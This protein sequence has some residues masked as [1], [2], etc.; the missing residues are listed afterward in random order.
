M[1]WKQQIEEAYESG[2]TRE[3]LEPKRRVGARDSGRE[4][5]QQLW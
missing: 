2:K 3:N 4:G 1:K 5:F